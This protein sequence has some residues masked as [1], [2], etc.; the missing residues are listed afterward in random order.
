MLLGRS[1]DI[2]LVFALI[3]IA[4]LNPICGTLSGAVVVYGLVSVC[5]CALFNSIRQTREIIRHEGA[6]LVASKKNGS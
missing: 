2:W 5:A 4:L 1:L 6:E 3:A